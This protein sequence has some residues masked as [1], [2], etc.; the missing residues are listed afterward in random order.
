MMLYTAIKN[1]EKEEKNI[2]MIYF[3]KCLLWKGNLN[4]SKK[5]IKI[6]LWIFFLHLPASNVKYFTLQSF[7]WLSMIIIILFLLKSAN[8]LINMSSVH[9]FA[10]DWFFFLI[11]NNS[12]K[13]CVLRKNFFLSNILSEPSQNNS[14]WSMFLHGRCNKL[15]N[16]LKT[17][18]VSHLLKIWFSPKD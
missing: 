2:K 17:H 16:E 10:S 13:I 8:T 11:F 12:R 14:F 5:Q 4:Q 6:I 15:L 7:V 1:R 3:I 18:N 9:V